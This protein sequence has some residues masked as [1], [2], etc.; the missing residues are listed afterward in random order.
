[1]NAVGGAG[2]LP[3]GLGPVSDL[4]KVLLKMT[5]E[6]SGVA[7][8]LVASS[9]DL[10]LIAAFGEDAKVPALH[11]WR[12]EVFGDAALKLRAGETALAAAGNRLTTVP[13]KT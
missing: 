11:G 10:E 8:K 1:M 4:L 6:E 2:P 9:A 12:R 5:C 3:R 13:V 7:R